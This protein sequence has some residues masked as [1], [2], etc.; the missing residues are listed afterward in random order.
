MCEC[1]NVCVCVCVQVACIVCVHVCVCVCVC[2]R[3]IYRGRTSYEFEEMAAVWVPPKHYHAQLRGRFRASRRAV[4]RP[5]T[6]APHSPPHKPRPHPT[7]TQSKQGAPGSG[8]RPLTCVHMT[9]PLPAWPSTRAARAASTV[10]SLVVRPGARTLVESDIMSAIGS[11]SGGWRRLDGGW[12]RLVAVGSEVE[13]HVVVG[14][15]GF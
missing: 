11:L 3:A 2:E 5:P 13:G 15:G 8:G 10:R 12:R 14:G 9:R 6:G 4:P 7:P 1:V